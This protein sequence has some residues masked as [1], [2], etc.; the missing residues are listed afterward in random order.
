M[1]PFISTPEPFAALLRTDTVR[2]A[3]VIKAANINA[4]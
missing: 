2:F 3:E 1:V 4:G